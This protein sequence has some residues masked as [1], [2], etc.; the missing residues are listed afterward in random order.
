MRWPPEPALP[1]HFAI[2]TGEGFAGAPPDPDYAEYG[3][4]A[5]R[6]TS[7]STFR[8]HRKLRRTAVVPFLMPLEDARTLAAKVRYVRK[9]GPA[10]GTTVYARK[11]SVPGAA[12]PGARLDVRTR[13]TPAGKRLARRLGARKLARALAEH[14]VLDM[15]STSTNTSYPFTK[16]Y[17]PM[18]TCF[19]DAQRPHG[20]PCAQTCP[21]FP[22]MPTGYLIF[23]AL[24]RMWGSQVC[25]RGD[26]LP[27][28]PMG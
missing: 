5:H 4:L 27:P 1:G 22:D 12:Q 2:F 13:L 19:T 23:G 15:T 24:G 17:V 6:V 10:W 16:I 7:P 20:H 25:K 18:G 21:R 3:K 8:R 9:R 14:G 28:E 26:P 11:L